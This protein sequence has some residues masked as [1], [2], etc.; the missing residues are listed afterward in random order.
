MQHERRYY[1]D[2]NLA[3]IWRSAQH[4]RADDIY[5]W[6]THFLDT[7]RQLKSSDS[8]PQSMQRRATALVWKRLPKSPVHQ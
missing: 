4:R 5:S 7:R 2:D 6:L 1:V 3:D 8:R